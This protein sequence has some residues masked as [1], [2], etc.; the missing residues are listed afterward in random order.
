MGKFCRAGRATDKI[1]RMR[2]AC[3]V[4]KATNTNSEYVILIA[5][6]LQQC[7]HERSSTPTACLT[8]LCTDLFHSQLTNRDCHGLTVNSQVSSPESEQPARHDVDVLTYDWTQ[9]L[10]YYEVGTLVCGL[11]RQTDRQTETFVCFSGNGA[12]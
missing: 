3:R 4:P 9:I 10:S 2:I 12:Q 1:R 7:L 5:F 8:D 6:P 11:G